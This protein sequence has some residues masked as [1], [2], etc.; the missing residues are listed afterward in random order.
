MTFSFFLSF[1]FFLF[2]LACLLP[3]FPP[4]LL[5]FFLFCFL[6]PH[7]RHM[8]IPRSGV[9]SELQQLAYTTTTA[10]PDLSHIC[11]LQHSSRQHQILNPLS[12]ARD[13]TMDTGQI[14]FCRA[15]KGIPTMTFSNQETVTLLTSSWESFN[16]ISHETYISVF[17]LSA[18]W[19]VD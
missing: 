5:F 3:S 18:C 13:Q 11:N 1:F 10:M 16:L 7:L 9:K 6:G 4:S 14:H 8:E 15:K 19:R 12:K 2:L 17:I